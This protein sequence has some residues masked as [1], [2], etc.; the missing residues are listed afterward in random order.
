MDV[1]A[2]EACPLAVRRAPCCALHH[3]V[4]DAVS[5]RRARRAPQRR[6]RVGEVTRGVARIA[7]LE[8]PISYKGGKQPI[9]SQKIFQIFH[10]FFIL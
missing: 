10:C 5:R 3:R 7:T 9:L 8:G 6:R 1:A 4:L 2:N